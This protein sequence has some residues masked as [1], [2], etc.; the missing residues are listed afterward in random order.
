MDSKYVDLLNGYY[1]W[2]MDRIKIGS[3]LVLEIISNNKITIKE[4]IKNLCAVMFNFKYTV[5]GESADIVFLF[6]SHMCKRKDHIQ[7]FFHITES[8]ANKKIII[9]PSKKNKRIQAGNVYFY[10]YIIVWIWQIRSLKMPLLFKIDLLARLARGATEAARLEKI[11][12]ME[13][14]SLL[15]V[16]YD[17]PVHNSIL[18][19]R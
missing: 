15:V 13:R 19:K 4:C 9:C 16:Y 11:I 7:A 5:T 12:D 8:F 6:D 14:A 18:I 10:F 17:L 2:K 3:A 1:F